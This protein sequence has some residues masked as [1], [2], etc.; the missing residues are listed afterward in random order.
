MQCLSCG[1][2]NP[3]DARFCTE[4]A[5]R[6]VQRCPTCGTESFLQA[7]FCGKCATP[8]HPSNSAPTRGAEEV[9]SEEASASRRIA[10]AGPRN[11][12]T[13]DSVEGERRH[14]TVLMSDVVDSTRIAA[15][16]DPEEWRDIATRCERTVAETVVRFGG[17]VA[18]YLGDG[19]VA[20][21]GYPQAHE[22]DAEQAVR[23][24]LAIVNAVG[25]LNEQLSAEHR[26]LLR[27]RV[28]I[29][30]GSVV[31][32]NTARLEAEVFGDPPN[33]AAR[34]Q[35]LAEPDTVVV[36]AAT[37]RLVS[38]LF[39]VED[40][41]GQAL[42]GIAEPVQLFRVLRPSGV[43][44]G[45]HATIA[46][47]G[48][49]PFV[50]REDELR[51]LRN[52]WERVQDG[53]GH[54][55][56]IAGEAGI[57]K[58]RLVQHFRGLISGTPHTWIES[59]GVP[60]LQSTPFHVVT[61][62][63][64]QLFG[65]HDA[66]APEQRVRDLERSLEAAGLPL[67]E[68]LPLLAPLLGLPVPDRYSASLL[69]PED[70]HRRL[71][72]TLAKWVFAAAAFQ[73]L[74]IVVED[75]HWVDPSTLDLQRLLAEQGATTPLLLMHTARSEFQPPWPLRA[76]HV[77]IILNRLSN[78]Q[79]REM[80]TRVAAGKSLATEVVEAVAQRTD[81]VPLFV[82]ELTR[83]VVDS[84]KDAV[85]DT[86]P[87]TLQDS[88]MARLDRLG[89]AK[90]IVQVAAVIGR[91]FSYELLR[92]I[93]PIADAELQDGLK[94]AADAELL[95]PRG[96]P[97]DATYVFKH[98]LV[99]DAAYQALLK[100]KR[101]EL[102]RN[103]AK[104]LSEAFPDLAS[105]QPELVAH[106]YAEAGE[107]LQAASE[108]Q[109]AAD[110]AVARGA[111]KEA[112]NRLATAIHVLDE[113]TEASGLEHRK[114]VLQVAL[115]QVLMAT[116]GY[117]A[118][119]VRAA[120]ARAGELGE[121]VGDPAQ[122]IFTLMGLWV[123]NLIRCELRA[124]QAVADQ[125]LAAAEAHGSLRIWGHL[126]N[127]VTRYHSG[128]L[129]GA[130]L[131]LERATSLYRE[132]FYSAIPQDPGVA[133]LGYG[134][135]TAWQLGMTDTARARSDSALDLAHRLQKPF[136]L[137]SAYSFAAGIHLLLG[138]P[139][140]AREYADALTEVAT[141]HHMP[142]YSADGIILRGRVLAERDCGAKGIEMMREGVRQQI[143]NGQRV[144]LGYYL[145]LLG[146]AYI[147]AGAL[148]EALAS[149]EEALTAVPEERVDHPRLLHLRGEIHLKMAAVSDGD[150]VQN[151]R[152]RAERSLHE[153]VAAARA[154]GAK[155]S[156]L[157]AVT[158]LGRM[159]KSFGR[160]SEIRDVLAALYGTFSE[161]FDTAALKDAK[162]LLDELAV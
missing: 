27:V 105:S 144:G 128:D 47:S 124:A 134:S 67:V 60:F 143:T 108:W 159:L 49:T 118:A 106:H 160:A 98:S 119:E 63:L 43:R 96:L 103:I 62:T 153:A 84:G 91:E 50:G 76:H 23:A 33:V 146:E 110:M 17:Y 140:R 34:V 65:W 61:E 38:G 64:K 102:H 53:E 93:L 136:D 149:V 58:S 86:I 150:S 12:T 131:H 107:A 16:L 2:E 92:A 73:P 81:G 89:P 74:V 22:N 42:R 133:A 75:L 157:R 151:H 4:C 99:Q 7:K 8:L 68:A 90:E 129:A 78:H 135:R 139:D 36:T 94:Q 28:G 1:S 137:A 141:E 66:E 79:A 113:T 21:F 156:G 147:Q 155:T 122:V 116:K 95:Y 70:Q 19:L 29:D 46:V 39:A 138:E 114:L 162:A 57:G 77:H 14:L 130:W 6:L 24:G 69:P 154:I 97:P 48:L 55:V 111:L 40:C 15:S 44:S 109:R 3:G 35:A 148:E 104:V 158:I 45:L 121:R 13:E 52:R 10:T 26:P 20:Y 25:A 85:A 145:A 41:G 51:M 120:Y 72:A 88:L 83:L 71:L 132:D 87:A 117:A 152:D 112:E 82:E 100:S 126:A 18:K 9:R 127:G 125:V 32:G 80:V 115:G 101:R 54:V 37:H 31:I 30:A 11:G 123:S 5:T 56:M 142:F 59:G 161:G